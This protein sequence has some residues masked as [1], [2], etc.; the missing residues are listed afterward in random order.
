MIVVIVFVLVR[1]LSHR[2]R[3]QLGG[4]QTRRDRLRGFRSELREPDATSGAAPPALPDPRRDL[5]LT[6]EA[7]RQEYVNG[8]ITVEEYE[9]RLDELYRTAAG[10]N[11]TRDE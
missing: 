2:E 7:V 1:L 11:L 10:R 8:R 3:G 6:I 9:R 4:W 5:Q